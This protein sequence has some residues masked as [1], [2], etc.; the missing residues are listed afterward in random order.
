MSGRALA[1]S[2]VLAAGCVGQA[3]AQ[4]C[5]AG[6]TQV[7]NLQQLVGGNTLCAARGSDRWQ[8]FHS[9]SA[10]GALIDWKLGAAHPIDPTETVGSWSASNGAN[11]LLTHTYGQ[12]SYAWRVC[13][14]APGSYTLVSTNGGGMITGATVRSGQV[15][16]P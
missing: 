11:S 3:S 4:S 16:C 9:G 7:M 10:S 5:P 6:T 14:A 15:A 1:V 13:Q 12:T 8:E 2:F